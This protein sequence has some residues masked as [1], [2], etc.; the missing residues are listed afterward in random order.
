[1]FVYKLV[2]RRDSGG[3]EWMPVAKASTGKASIG[4]AKRAERLLRN[5]VAVA[6][7]IVIDDDRDGLPEAVTPAD[8]TARPLTVALM[9][10]GKADARWLGPAGVAA[11]R[12][13]CAAAVAELPA[14]A[15]R[16]SRGEPAL[17]TLSV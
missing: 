17:P 14:A 2:A 12:E 15:L 11:A 8:L 5:G 4:G 6:E 3:D 9:T 1:G 16:L 7:R 13:H 10:D